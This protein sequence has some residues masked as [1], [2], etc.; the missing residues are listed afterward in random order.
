MHAL[1]FS[2]FCVMTKQWTMYVTEHDKVMICA[3]VLRMYILAI[4]VI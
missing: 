1:A 4:D 3:I 2:L